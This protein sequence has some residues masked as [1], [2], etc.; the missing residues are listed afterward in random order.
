M[1]KKYNYFDDDIE[2]EEKKPKIEFDLIYVDRSARRRPEDIKPKSSVTKEKKEHKK[3]NIKL[4]NIKVPSVKVN[5][6]SRD[7]VLK[8]INA[9]SSKATSLIKRVKNSNPSTM[10]RKHRWILAILI[11]LAFAIIIGVTV[12]STLSIVTKEAKNQADFQAA[13]GK[14]CMEYEE[15]YGAA[16]FENLSD[17]GITG[18]RMTGLCYIRDLDFN[19]DKQS[20]LLICYLQGKTYNY[21]IWGY[22]GESFV[23]LHKAPLHQTEKVSDHAWFTIYTK[24]GQ[25]YIVEHDKKNVKK[26]TIYELKGTKF[27]KK[28]DVSFDIESGDYRIKGKPMPDAFERVKMGVISTHEASTMSERI[29][30]KADGFIGK[31]AKN[32]GHTQ[33]VNMMNAYYDVILDYNNKYGEAKFVEGNSVDYID[34]LAYVTLIDFNDDDVDELVLAYRRPVNTKSLNYNGD[35]VATTVDRYFCDVYSW[36]GTNAWRVY[37]QEGLGNMLNDE[38]Q[39]YILF[40]HSSGKTMLCFSTFKTENYGR[41]IEASSKVLKF[42]GQIFKPSM[43]AWYRTD[44]GYTEYRLNGTYVNQYQF[45]QRG[46]YEVPFFDGSTTLKNSDYT[47]VYLQTDKNNDSRIDNI[48]PNTVDA[49]KKINKGYEPSNK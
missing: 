7:E 24:N 35:Y 41:I 1:A 6:P 29:Q 14:V 10:S 4:P 47:I 5:M 31:R 28:E 16:S 36:N 8:K 18:A 11:I 44:Y 15:T 27:V 17:K 48:V 49:I 42:N 38:A 26:A 3:S 12:W 43:K 40:K 37:Q 22:S 21:E 20:E 34:G 13:A 45:K 33:K 25:N 9:G 46:A 2:V 19:N 32:N 23:M 30:D 39:R